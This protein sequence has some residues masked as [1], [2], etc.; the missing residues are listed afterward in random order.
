[1]VASLF[2]CIHYSTRH[3]I[4]STITSPWPLIYRKCLWS[5]RLAISVI[6]IPIVHGFGSRSFEFTLDRNSISDQV[7][8][9]IRIPAGW[10]PKNGDKSRVHLPRRN[11]IASP[12]H[13]HI[14]CSPEDF[15]VANLFS[16]NFLCIFCYVYLLFCY[17]V[18]HALEEIIS[19]FNWKSCGKKGKTSSV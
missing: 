10:I 2:P 8:C 6:C 11:Y 14:I 5:W 1:M 19:R 7:Q 18:I 15:T 3:Y 13:L 17:F 9:R 4:T 16:C 12:C